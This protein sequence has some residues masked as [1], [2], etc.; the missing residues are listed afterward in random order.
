MEMYVMMNSSSLE[1]SRISKGEYICN[2][3]E[4]A[5]STFAFSR[6][7]K[8]LSLELRGILLVCAPNLLERW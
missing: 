5:F 2:C 4:I 1:K 7:E 3:E 8:L 6:V